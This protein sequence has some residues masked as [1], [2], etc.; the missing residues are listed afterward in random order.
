MAAKRQRPAV[1][2]GGMALAIAG[3]IAF[4]IFAL[5]GSHLPWKPLLFSWL[6]AVNLTTFFFYAFDKSRVNA[7][8]GRVPELVLHGLAVVGGSPGAFAGMEIFRHKTAKKP[9][10]I[11]FWSIVA[12]QIVFMLPTHEKK[13]HQKK[14]NLFHVFF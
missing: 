8:G 6:I 12:I 9:F 5:V 13:K 10:R 7:V 3:A 11:A 1:V 2:Y 14:K 4:A